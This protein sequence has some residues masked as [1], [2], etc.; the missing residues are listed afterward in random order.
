VSA[1]SPHRAPIGP[2]PDGP[3][4][5]LWSV[6]IPTYDGAARLATALESVLAQDPGPATMQIEVVDDHSPSAE[7]E[8]LVARLGGGRVG[9]HRQPRNR[10]H[11]GNFNTC[12]E[13]ARGRL[14]HILHDD[15]HVLPGFYERLGAGLAAAPEAGAAF[16]R[17]IYADHDGHWL[18]L[19]GI[20]RREPGLLDDWLTKIASGQRLVTPSVVVRREVYERLGGYDDRIRFAGE[21]WEMWVRIAAHH[22]VWFEPEPLAVYQI[23]RPGSLTQVAEGG[24]VRE[25]RHATEIVES[26]LGEHLPPAAAREATAHARR[27]YAGWAVDWAGVLLAGRDLRGAREQA[28]EALAC[29]RSGS[30][31]RALAVALGRGAIAAVK[32]PVRRRLGALRRRLRALAGR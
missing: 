17:H 29:S 32:P 18:S 3:E 11:V 4:R 26:Y 31:L 20:E 25:M 23:K 27:F 5:P 28:G 21:D 1:G 16:C 6:M 10:G 12:I 14:V 15:D 22:P 30:T 8:R 2:A 24:I 19:S 13:R 9:F 7:A